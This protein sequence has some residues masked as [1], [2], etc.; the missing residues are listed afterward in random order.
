MLG[1]LLLYSCII[2][3]N[4]A[5]WSGGSVHYYVCVLIASTFRL[6]KLFAAVH[7]VLFCLAFVCEA[8]NWILFIC[9]HHSVQ[10]LYTDLWENDLIMRL[11]APTKASLAR[12][13]SAASLSIPGKETPGNRHRVESWKV[14]VFALKGQV[15][16]LNW[17]Q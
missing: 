17:L 1:P 7:I 9:S 16:S 11:I 10:Q 8:S 2:F 4:N 6:R 15:V 3:P 12:S 14:L 13:K 5:V